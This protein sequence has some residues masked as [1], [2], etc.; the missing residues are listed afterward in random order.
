MNLAGVLTGFKPEDDWFGYLLLND[1]RFEGR[2]EAARKRARARKVTRIA[3][4]EW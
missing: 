3:D 4:I 1:P 2:I